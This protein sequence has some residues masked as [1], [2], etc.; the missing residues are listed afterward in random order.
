[1]F[2][3]APSLAKMGESDDDKI[4]LA[5]LPIWSNKPQGSIPAV[6]QDKIDKWIENS[7]NSSLKK[8]WKHTEQK[9]IINGSGNL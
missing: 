5:L 2:E 3:R 8:L 9:R 4:L 1:L 7:N 6:L